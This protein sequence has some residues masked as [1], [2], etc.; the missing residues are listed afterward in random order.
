MNSR[1]YEQGTPNRSARHSRPARPSSFCRPCGLATVCLLAFTAGHALAEPNLLNEAKMSDQMMRRILD[2]MAAVQDEM[3]SSNVFRA[4]D[5]SRARAVRSHLEVTRTTEMPVIIASL[6]KS[7]IERHN[8]TPHYRKAY[9]GHQRIVNV[10]ETMAGA[11]RR[12]GAANAAQDALKEIRALI[13]AVEPLVDMERDKREMT[14]EDLDRYAEMANRAEAVAQQLKQDPAGAL[15]KEAAQDL[16]KMDA[17]DAMQKLPKAADML[18][19]TLEEARTQLS[20]TAQQ[21]REL[22]ALLKALDKDIAAAKQQKVKPDA[23]QAM[24]AI[25]D[26]DKTKQ[27]LEASALP[28]AAQ[29]V[30][31]AQQQMADSKPDEALEN[32]NAARGEVAEKRDAL[33]EQ[34]QNMMQEQAE[35]MAALDRMDAYDQALAE[36]MKAHQEQTEQSGKPADM[37]D[38]AQQMDKLGERMQQDNL[39]SP[40]KQMEKAGEATRSDQQPQAQAAMQQARADLQKAM[41]EARQ[42]IAEAREQAPSAEPA[43]IEALQQ[44]LANLMSEHAQKHQKGESMQELA[45]RMKALA[46]QMQDNHLKKPG[47]LMQQAGEQTQQDQSA[48]A[49]QSMSQAQAA[50]AQ[51]LSEAKAMASETPN[52]VDPLMVPGEKSDPYAGGLVDEQLGARRTGNAWREQLPERERQ[53]LLAARQ[54]QFSPQMAESV[55]QYFEELAKTR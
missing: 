6:E 19:K 38:L 25:M 42:A 34:M 1:Y 30:D 21:Q 12:V 40:A 2:R 46:A 4:D 39:P 10:L 51:A 7:I 24:Q 16:R 32:L 31:E 11:Q 5:L 23:D 8:P 55:R 48:Q 22:D 49:Q 15:V 20:E 54:E 13:Q 27:A 37:Q 17:Q 29:K 3:E 35:Q 44:E 33:A 26:M 41:Q 9:D 36:M 53:A 43:Q 28:A 45:E 14:Q 52:S 18:A 50:L 47:E